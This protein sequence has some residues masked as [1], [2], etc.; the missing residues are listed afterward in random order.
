MTVLTHWTRSFV[1]RVIPDALAVPGDGLVPTHGATVDSA[2]SPGWMVLMCT[3]GARDLRYIN[4]MGVRRSLLGWGPLLV[5]QELGSGGV[6]SCRNFHHPKVWLRS[7]MTAVCG[8][9]GTI[10]L[11]GQ[12]ATPSGVHT[13]STATDPELLNSVLLALSCGSECGGAE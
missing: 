4:R 13:Y 9:I 1:A 11:Q 2:G 3:H 5:R 8:L 6:G 12:V 10:L 7:M